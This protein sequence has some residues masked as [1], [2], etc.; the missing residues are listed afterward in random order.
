[1]SANARLNLHF[2]GWTTTGIP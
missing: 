2:Y 1:M